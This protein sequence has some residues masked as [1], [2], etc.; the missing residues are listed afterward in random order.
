M[1]AVLGEQHHQE[2]YVIKVAMP[3]CFGK[4]L[5]AAVKIASRGIRG[6]GYIKGPRV[7]CRKSHIG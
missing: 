6:G 2:R 7:S 4:S 3:K 1:L 5:R